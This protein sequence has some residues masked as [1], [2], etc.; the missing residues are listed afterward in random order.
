LALMAANAALPFYGPAASGWL[1]SLNTQ[2][3]NDCCDREQTVKNIT[4]RFSAPQE[5]TQLPWSLVDNGV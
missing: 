4:G 5:L 1:L 3:L 2:S